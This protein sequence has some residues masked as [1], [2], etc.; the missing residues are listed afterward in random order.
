MI[1]SVFTILDSKIGSYMNPFY[2]KNKGQALRDFIDLMKDSQ[3]VISKH[4]EDYSL[5]EIGS[6]DQDS[7]C[8]KP[9]KVL[10]FVADSTFLES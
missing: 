6:F 1:L 5:Y 2:A 8:L 3:S 4:P 7:A 10:E 9:F